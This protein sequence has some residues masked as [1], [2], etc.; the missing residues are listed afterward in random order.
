MANGQTDMLVTLIYWTPR[1]PQGW[2][3]SPEHQLSLL[4]G[5]GWNGTL[6]LSCPSFQQLLGQGLGRRR[7]LRELH[8]GAGGKG[9]VQTPNVISSSQGKTRAPG[10]LCVESADPW[11]VQTAACLTPPP[12]CFQAC[13]GGPNHPTRSSLGTGCLG[14]SAPLHFT[15]CPAERTFRRELPSE[16]PKHPA[17][18]ARAPPTASPKVVSLQRSRVVPVLSLPSP[19]AP[20]GSGA[21]GCLVGG[22][23]AK[24]AP[25][26][27][28]RVPEGGALFG[29]TA[30]RGRRTVGGGQGWN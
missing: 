30:C 23:P 8:L 7:L 12:L 21:P 26:E 22:V 16:G 19:G 14:H 11:R 1:S 9:E 24:K 28:R 18:R 27:G 13:W 10:R 4:A 17:P 6:P 3:E 15:R 25:I 29:A 20:R 2:V 5:S